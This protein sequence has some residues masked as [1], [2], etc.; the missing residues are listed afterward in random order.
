MSD[1]EGAGSRYVFLITSQYCPDWQN[2][3]RA[4]SR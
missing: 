2:V 4:K 3:P 1:G